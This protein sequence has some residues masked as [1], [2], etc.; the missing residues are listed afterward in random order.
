MPL[1]ERRI[2]LFRRLDFKFRGSCTNIS[3]HL[4]FS[5]MW[6]ASTYHRT[7]DSSARPPHSMLFY[8]LLLKLGVPSRSRTDKQS[9]RSKHSRFTVFAYGDINNQTHNAST[10]RFTDEYFY[11]WTSIPFSQNRATALGLILAPPLVLATSTTWFQRPVSR[12]LRFQG[13]ILERDGGTAPP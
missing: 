2:K 13:N 3:T 12:L 11:S 6:R 9:L 5:R 10:L 8:Q 4:G 1:E 7:L